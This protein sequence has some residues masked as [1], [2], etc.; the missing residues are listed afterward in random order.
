MSGSIT[1]A[2]QR[3]KNGEANAQI[4][5]EQMLQPFLL[6]LIGLVR[7]HREKP[8]QPRIDSEGVVYHALHSFLTGVAKDEFPQLESR[9]EV[10]KVLTT[11]VRRT[12]CDQVRW[13]KR[14]AR[15]PDREQPSPDGRPQHLADSTEQR[16]PAD[17][18]V[19]DLAAWLEK[20]FAVLRPVHPR[21][22]EIVEL[23][24]KGLSNNDIAQQVGLGVRRV[25][26]L[27][28][29]MHQLLQQAAAA[30]NE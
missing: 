30:E 18:A 20:L 25:Q 1:N 19:P 2:V 27:K 8:L 11:L 9:V 21:A 12:L 15:T 14:Q 3:W 5:L 6:D 22:I 23:S 17:G 16:P 26:V 10:K 24:L 28:R 7:R 4:D 13:H 29:D